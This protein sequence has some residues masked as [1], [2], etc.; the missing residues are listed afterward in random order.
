V[1]TDKNDKTVKLSSKRLEEIKEF[2]IVYTEDSPRLTADQIARM[3]PAHPEYW[4]VE[5]VKVSVSIKVDADV[6]R[7]SNH[8]ARGIRPE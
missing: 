2:P 1:L 4:K 7:G 6:L 5:P 8:R 3:K